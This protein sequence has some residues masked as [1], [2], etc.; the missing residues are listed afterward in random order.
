MGNSAQPIPRSL[1]GV[2]ILLE[3]FKVAAVAATEAAR[4]NLIRSRRQRRG[5]TLHPGADTPLWNILAGALNE[6]CKKYGA[7][8]SL[9]RHIGLPRQR[10]HDFLRGKSAMPDAERALMLL[11]WLADRRQPPAQI[12]GKPV[13]KVTT[14]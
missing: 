11:Q 2:L 10:M 7:K 6:E 9:A 12:A 4:R 13:R 8:A 3:L 5:K 14:A 1:E